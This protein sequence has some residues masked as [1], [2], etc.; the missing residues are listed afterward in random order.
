[1]AG[2]GKSTIAH[3]VAYQ[4]FKQRRLAASFFFSRGGGDVG[5]ARK[6]VTTIAVQLASHIPPVQR[7]ICNVLT[8]HSTITSQS[9]ADQWRLLVLGPLLKLDGTDTF[10]SYIVVI[11]ALDECEGESYVRIILRLLAETQSLKTVRLRVLITSRPEIP[12]RYGFCQIPETEHYDFIL[13]DIET[14]IVEHD[15]SIFLEY[16]MRSTRLEWNLEADWPGEQALQRLVRNA[17]GLFIWAATA[18]RFIREGRGYATRRLSTILDDSTSTL[19]PELHLNNIYL[20][21]LRNTIRQEY[22]EKEIQDIYTFLR[23]LLGT[24]VTL[25]SP[26]SVD[27]LSALLHIT[28]GDIGHGL[29]DLHAILDIPQDAQRPLRLHHPSFRDF[30]LN[31]DRCSDPHFWVDEKQT[32]S[33]QA[34]NCI[35][36]MSKMLREDICSVGAPGYLAT[37]IERSRVERCLPSEVQYACLYW[38]EHLRK[39]GAQLSDNEWVHQFLREHILH[40]LEALSWLQKVSEGIQAVTSLESIA[41]VS[42]FYLQQFE[43]LSN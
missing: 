5:N 13:H 2:T 19:A 25:H 36:L 38:I 28:K 3:T 34:E 15:I 14:A 8:E 32:H 20:T 40:W 29:T 30:L 24:V 16:E 31:R 26:L 21:V 33:F 10:Q 39:S 22:T 17:G 9:L 42:L 1:M 4:Y 7:H 6:F 18:C 12:L 35:R 11:D 27:S 23:Q 41:I 37:D 43:K